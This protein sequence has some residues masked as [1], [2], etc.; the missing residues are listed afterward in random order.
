MTLGIFGMQMSL[1]LLSV[2][3][4]EKFSVK[5]KSGTCTLSQAA[6]KIKLLY[7]VQGLLIG[8]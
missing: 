5:R 4:L 2:P 6:L 1:V 7:C 3:K 8:R